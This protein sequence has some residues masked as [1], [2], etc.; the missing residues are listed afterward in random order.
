MATPRDGIAC[1]F[2]GCARRYCSILRIAGSAVW[3]GSSFGRP[4][5]ARRCVPVQAAS[6]GYRESRPRM[7]VVIGMKFVQR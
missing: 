4:A 5:V 7:Q 6:P 1:R 3:A 2:A